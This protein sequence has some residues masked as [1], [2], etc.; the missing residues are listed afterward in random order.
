MDNS[1]ILLETG[2]NVPS[3]HIKARELFTELPLTKYVVSEYSF[4]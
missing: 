2:I 4:K 1:D 3:S